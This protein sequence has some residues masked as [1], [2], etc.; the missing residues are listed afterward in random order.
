MDKM[1]IEKLVMV[2][3]YLASNTG[4]MPVA[5]NSAIF[6]W[7]GA[8]VS[9]APDCKPM[10]DLVP[11]SASEDLGTEV[12]AGLEHLCRTMNIPCGI[13]PEDEEVH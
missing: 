3:S 10:V 8:S 7:G 13:P 11:G 2:V 1:Q 9:A 6:D 12:L 4:Y 5:H